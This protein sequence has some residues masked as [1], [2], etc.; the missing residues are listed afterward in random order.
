MSVCY[1]DVFCG[2]SQDGKLRVWD[3]RNFNRLVQDIPKTHGYSKTRTI[4]MGLSCVIYLNSNSIITCSTDDC[5]IKVWDLRKTFRCAHRNV[6]PLPLKK[7]YCSNPMLIDMQLN[8][9]SSLLYASVYGSDILCFSLNST[10][11]TPI[12][13]YTGRHLNSMYSKISISHDGKYIFSGCSQNS[14][15]IWTTKLPHIKEPIFELNRKVKYKPTYS[16]VFDQEL[17]VSD[18]CSDSRTH[19]KSSGE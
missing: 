11:R 6:K 1:V 5:E 18:W 3:A 9:Q 15:V 7:Y 4:G 17:G 12:H 10:Q 14:G 19:P 2:G 8:P 16:Y 13:Q